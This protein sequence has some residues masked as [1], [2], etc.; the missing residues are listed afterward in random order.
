MSKRSFEIEL[1]LQLLELRDAL[2]RSS[3]A[4]RDLQHAMDVAS[5]KLAK[6]SVDEILKKHGF[7]P[8]ENQ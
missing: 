3:L 1:A 8:D 6:E 2:V 4:L 7:Y 5:Q